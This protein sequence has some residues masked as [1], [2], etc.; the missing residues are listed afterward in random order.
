MEA[1][2]VPATGQNL[3][4]RQPRYSKEHFSRLGQSLYETQ[5]CQHVEQGNKGRIVAIDTSLW[6]R[7]MEYGF[8][9]RGTFDTS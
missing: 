4:A 1:T 8:S 2:H 6:L 3:R 9:Y 5:V 7:P